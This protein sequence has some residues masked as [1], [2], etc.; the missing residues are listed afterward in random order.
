MTFCKVAPRL[1][2]FCC[3]DSHLRRDLVQKITSLAERFAPDN[4]WH[5][6]RKTLFV[7][8]QA[9]VVPVVSNR[10]NI[11]QRVCLRIVRDVCVCV[12][13]S[14]RGPFGL[15][16]LM[17]GARRLISYPCQRSYGNQLEESWDANS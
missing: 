16:V 14:Q 10:N 9:V 1:P 13:W 6:P 2:S 11:L 3:K 12:C 15:L 7:L 17:Q 5:P 8:V 4:E